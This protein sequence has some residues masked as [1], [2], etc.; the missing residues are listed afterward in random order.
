[1]FSDNVNIMTLA[2]PGLM[3][4]IEDGITEGKELEDF[5]EKLFSDVR[6]IKFDSV[7]LGCT[8]YPHI[9]ET[10][11]KVLGDNIMVFDGGEGTAKET[12]RRLEASGIINKSKENGIV[13]ITCSSKEKNIEELSLKL[14]KS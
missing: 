1:R 8:H 2:C 7:V 14:L 11:K 5:L 6:G 4:Y 13:K 10:I 3:E 12:K 9:K